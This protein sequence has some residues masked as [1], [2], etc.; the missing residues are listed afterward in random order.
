[1]QFIQCSGDGDKLTVSESHF[2]GNISAG[3]NGGAIYVQGGGIVEVL[4]SEIMKTSAGAGTSDSP[5]ELEDGMKR[6]GGGAISIFN[7]A[8]VIVVSTIVTE[9]KAHTEKGYGGAFRVVDSSLV[10]N[11][12]VL[13][14]C[15][16]NQGGAI[17]VQ[18][19]KLDADNVTST[20]CKATKGGRGGSVFAQGSKKRAGHQEQCLH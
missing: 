5:C 7:G 19:S 3:R 2:T 18:N 10:L 20:S 9:T 6:C 4:D 17:Y 13:T 15:A 12:V 1:M 14:G 11:G 8:S 16:A